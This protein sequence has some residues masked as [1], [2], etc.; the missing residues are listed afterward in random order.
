MSQIEEV[1][2]RGDPRIVL[3]GLLIIFVASLLNLALQI[4]GRISN[5]EIIIF[6]LVYV[7]GLLVTYYGYRRLPP[8]RYFFEEE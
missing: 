3:L 2:P 6:Y 5:R 7:M 8:K 1:S 4:L